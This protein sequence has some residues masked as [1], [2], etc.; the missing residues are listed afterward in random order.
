MEKELIPFRTFDDLALAEDVANTL[1]QNDIEYELKTIAPKIDVAT[2]TSAEKSYVIMALNDDFERI[3]KVLEDNELK[4]MEKIGSDYYLFKF[5]DSELMDVVKKADEWSAFDV[6]LARKILKDK[7]REITDK[8]M[9]NI[10]H[11][12]IEDLKQPE[13]SLKNLIMAGYVFALLGGLIGVFIGQYLAGYRKTLP[14]GEVVFAHSNSDRKH[15]RYILT[16]GTMVFCV[17]AV[18]KLMGKI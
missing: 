14:N 11:E 3:N 15:G 18:L 6:V 4:D 9:E 10:R 16:L 1:K 8:E 12:R 17:V 7:G 13:T 2:M 5:T